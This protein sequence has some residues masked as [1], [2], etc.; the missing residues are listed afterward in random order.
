MSLIKPAKITIPRLGQKILSFKNQDAKS[1]TLRL[2]SSTKTIGSIMSGRLSKRNSNAP[3]IA[4]RQS[5]KFSRVSSDQSSTVM[6]RIRSSSRESS[7]NPQGSQG[8]QRVILKTP[9]K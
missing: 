2:P 6:T 1:A 7:Q 4:S 3:S 8:H 5:S 9:Q